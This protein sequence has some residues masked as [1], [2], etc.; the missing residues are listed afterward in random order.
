MQLYVLLD[1]ENMVIAVGMSLLSRIQAEIYDISYLLPVNAAIFDLRHTQKSDSILTSL[2]VLP[3]PENIGIAFAI[4]LLSC[5][6]AEL[7]VISYLLPVN[8]RHL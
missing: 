8:G 5:I 3:D 2:I 1:P 7:H 4:S 6:P